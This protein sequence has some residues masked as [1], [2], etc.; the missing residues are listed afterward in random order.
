[1]VG[2]KIIMN[3]K[4]EYQLNRTGPTNIN[5]IEKY[6]QDWASGKINIYAS[7]NFPE[8]IGFPTMKA[9]DYDCFRNWLKTFKTEE[10]WS[11]KQLVEE[12]EMNHSAITWFKTPVWKING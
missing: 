5:W 10:V 1:M 7:D 3:K 11:L 2:R 8:E 4:V 6:G 12:Y 9:E